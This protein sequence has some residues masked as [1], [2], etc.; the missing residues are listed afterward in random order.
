VARARYEA[1]RAV[2]VR[3][4][5]AEIWPWLVQMGQGMG[6]PY[7]YEWLENLFGCDM[8]NADRIIPDFQHPDVG[9]IVRLTPKTGMVVAVVQPA[10]RSSSDRSQTY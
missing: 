7:I 5:A 8:Q 10:A 9:D 2:T 6:G 4:R 3:A 1:T